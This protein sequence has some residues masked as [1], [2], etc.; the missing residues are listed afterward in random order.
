MQ[1]PIER[2]GW[3]VNFDVGNPGSTEIASKFFRVVVDQSGP[4]AQPLII[5]ATDN[6]GIAGR[7]V[8]MIRRLLDDERAETWEVLVTT[9]RRA[10][11]GWSQGGL[12]EASR[13]SAANSNPALP[14]S[15]EVLWV[16]GAKLC[17]SARIRGNLKFG[18]AD[19]TGIDFDVPHGARWI[20][21]REFSLTTDVMGQAA[22]FCAFAQNL[23]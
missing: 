20:T 15:H 1:F 5:E 17:N 18:V 12:V 22:L 21:W 2:T 11:D 3:V 6:E 16:D 7:V 14:V 9:N 4:F 8:P 23:I 13:W 10:G 19:L